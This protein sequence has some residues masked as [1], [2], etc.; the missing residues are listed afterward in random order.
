MAPIFHIEKRSILVEKVAKQIREAIET[1]KLKSGERLIE[2]DLANGMQVS[3]SA[4]RESIRYLEKEGLVISTP[5]RGAQVAE[6]TDKDLEDLYALRM[7]LEELA[8]K[9]LIKTINEEKKKRLQGIVAGMQQVA[10]NGG[11]EEI[12]EADLGFHRAICELS[13]NR[14]LLEAWLN[15]SHQLRAFIALKDQLYD[16]ESPEMTL[17]LHYPVLDAIKNQDTKLA[18]REMKKVITR[19]YKKASQHRK[20]LKDTEAKL[21]ENIERRHYERS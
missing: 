2:N 17:G 14:R 7:A 12:I 6:F 8:I 20:K 15:L 18:V 21:K 1:G 16:D 10:K 13:G 4:I 11:I 19:G 3:R 9:T 5:F